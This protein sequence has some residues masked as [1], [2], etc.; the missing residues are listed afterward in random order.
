MY[1]TRSWHPSPSGPSSDVLGRRRAFACYARRGRCAWTLDVPKFFGGGEPLACATRNGAPNAPQ[2]ET[3]ATAAPVL[4]QAT[5]CRPSAG[6]GR[7][8]CNVPMALVREGVCR[9]A[10]TDRARGPYT[11]RRRPLRPHCPM[12]TC[13]P[14]AW[15]A[16]SLGLS[17]D[18]AL[19]SARTGREAS[20]HQGKTAR[21]DR[22][23]HPGRSFV[24][25][26]ASWGAG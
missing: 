9:R 11:A 23:C 25:S 24:L 5:E 19:R 10:R 2:K 15:R 22:Q 12:G 18:R 4:R 21:V 14:S 7:T 6:G 20:G 13:S 16:L 3:L 1:R 8:S 26:F 17:G